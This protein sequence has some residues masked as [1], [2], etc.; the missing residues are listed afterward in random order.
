MRQKRVLSVVLA[1]VGAALALGL[2]A[3]GLWFALAPDRGQDAFPRTPGSAESADMSGVGGPS[4][5]TNAGGLGSTAGAGSGNAAVQLVPPELARTVAAKY[6]ASRWKGCQVG[7]GLLAYAPDGRPEAYFFVVSKNGVPPTS[8]DELKQ[9]VSALRE[10]RLE[11]EGPRSQDR[12]APTDTTSAEVRV[13]WKQMRAADEYGTVVV[14]ANNGREP[15]IA[16]FAGLPPQIVLLE[17]ALQ[18]A[19]AKLG[20]GQR[21]EPQVIWRPPLFV[22]FKFRVGYAADTALFLEV[23]GNDLCE[24]P[25]PEWKRPVVPEEVLRQRRARWANLKE[26]AGG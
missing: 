18:M 22:F 15:F 26:T 16:S 25:S 17:D 2:V 14:G 23:R 21:P 24:V 7:E 19:A 10:R 9:R 6:A 20:T 1:A 11:A 4:A 3:V 5:V 8:P 12:V 13:L